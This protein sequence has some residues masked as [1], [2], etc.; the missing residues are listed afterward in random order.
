MRGLPFDRE[1]DERGGRAAY[2]LRIAHGDYYWS[3]DFS[4]GEQDQSPPIGKFATPDLK[5]VVGR[6]LVRDTKKRAAL[7]DLW[8]E[9]WMSGEGAPP[10]PSGL[11]EFDDKPVYYDDIPNVAKEESS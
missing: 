1:G 9:P 6:L 3:E 4:D 2:L 10:P 11:T 5:A 7:K 8:T